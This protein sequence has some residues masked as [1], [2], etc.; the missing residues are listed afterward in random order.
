ETLY[1]NVDV[2]AEIQKQLPPQTQALAPVAAAGL[3]QLSLRATNELLASARFQALWEQANRR[4]HQRL[5]DILNG[6]KTGHFE[7]A[8]GAV[9]LDLRPL[10]DRISNSGALGAG[11]TARPPPDGGQITILRSDQLKSAQDGV[12]VL[13]ALTVFLVIA[14]IGLYAIAIALGRPRRRNVLRASAVTF[15]FVGLIILVLRS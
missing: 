5:M 14:A 7:T 11:L 12:K 9:V 3:R 2:S 13:K 1:N 10:I 4:A 6:R 8:N 15:I